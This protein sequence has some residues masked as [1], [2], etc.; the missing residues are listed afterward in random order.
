MNL[1]AFKRGFISAFDPFA[2]APKRTASPEKRST[3]LEADFRVL[4]NAESL[5]QN[6]FDRA[7]SDVQQAN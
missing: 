2:S 7:L 5:I 1:N 6:A 3:T 4:N